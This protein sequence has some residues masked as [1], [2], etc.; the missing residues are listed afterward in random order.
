MRR[1]WTLVLLFTMAGAARAQI[2]TKG[3]VFF[4]YSY[5]RTPIVSN[6]TS[7]LNGWDATLEGKFAPWIGRSA[8]CRWPLRQPHLRLPRGWMSRA[9]QRYRTQCFV[10]PQGLGAGPALSTVRRVLIRSRPHQS[11]QRDFRLQYFIRGWTWRRPRLQNLRS[12]SGAR[13]AR[14]A[15]LSL[16]RPRPEWRALLDR[17]CGAFLAGPRGD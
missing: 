5:D 16:L 2:P 4:G 1:L 7:N 9:R 6:D 17:D 15:Q 12:G 8:R 11:Q 3:N 14:L 10:R 13:R